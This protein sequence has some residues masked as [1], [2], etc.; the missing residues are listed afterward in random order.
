[1]HASVGTSDDENGQ[2][3]AVLLW[4]DGEGEYES[5]VNVRH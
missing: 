5:G 3:R 1:M 2:Q 4:G